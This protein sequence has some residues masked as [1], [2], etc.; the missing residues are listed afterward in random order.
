MTW[1][2]RCHEGAAL[3]ESGD[4][5]GAVRIFEQLAADESADAFG[6]AMMYVNI[7]TIEAKGGSKLRVMKAYERAAGLALY[8]YMLVQSRR[9]AWL[10]ESRSYAEAEQLVERLLALPE[11]IA[12]DRAALEQN[13]KAIRAAGG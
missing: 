4:H 10:V 12:T 6:R 3:F 13:L 9:I 2:E 1:D 5:A 8:S 11:L 7:A